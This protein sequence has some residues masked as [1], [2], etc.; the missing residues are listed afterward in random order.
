MWGRSASAL[1]KRLAFIRCALAPASS[2]FKAA[3]FRQF[4]EI[5]PA[6]ITETSDT[7]ARCLTPTNTSRSVDSCRTH[8]ES[9]SRKPGNQ[10][11]H[12]NDRRLGT[13]SHSPSRRIA[14]RRR[15]SKSI[16]PPK[17]RSNAQ[18]A[19]RCD[20]GS[21]NRRNEFARRRKRRC[22]RKSGRRINRRRTLDDQAQIP[23]A[24]KP[25]RSHQASS[26]RTVPPKIPAENFPLGVS[27]RI[28]RR[29][30]RRITHRSQHQRQRF[31]VT[32]YERLGSRRTKAEQ[33]GTRTVLARFGIILSKNGGALPQMLTPFKLGA[34]GKLGSGKQWMSWI[35]PRRRRK[36]DP[37]RNNGRKSA[38]PNKYRSSQSSPQR[39]FHSRASQGPAS[40]SNSSS[41]SLRPAPSPR[42]NGRRPTPLQPA[43]SPR[44]TNPAALQ[45][46][47]C[48]TRIRPAPR[49]SVA[50]SEP[51]EL[52]GLCRHP[53]Q[54]LNFPV[55]ATACCARPM[56]AC[57]NVAY[58]PRRNAIRH[59]PHL[60]GL[61]NAHDV[62][63]ANPSQKCSKLVKARLQWRRN[64]R[65]LSAALQVAKKAEAS[66][67]RFR[68]EV[69]DLH[70]PLHFLQF[71]I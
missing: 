6:E 14:R 39:R 62:S 10:N 69:K 29:S 44:K 47:V 61:L 20:L 36:R 30:R 21:A 71:E 43:R 60:I 25:R 12:I 4:I 66:L 56:Y 38:R 11:A 57:E 31:P 42:R 9:S 19:R 15:N 2:H 28:L 68:L 18:Q 1:R 34:G 24:L 51:Y 33:F 45:I 63:Q 35:C 27:H 53:P 70:L 55:G 67:S 8:R 58:L 16:R 50:P 59:P 22:S 54:H 48:R 52:I 37:Q 13:S 64:L 17:R 65:F 40:P 32:N 41:P 23:A 49:T 5:I 3:A 46:S 7:A 26:N